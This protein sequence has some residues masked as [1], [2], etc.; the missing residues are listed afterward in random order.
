[1]RFL[2]QHHANPNAQSRG[3]QPLICVRCVKKFISNPKADYLE[4]TI[5]KILFVKWPSRCF[6]FPLQNLNQIFEK[7]YVLLLC[8]YWLITTYI[9]YVQ[10]QAIVYNINII[11]HNNIEGGGAPYVQHIAANYP[12]KR[13]HF[14]RRAIYFAISLHRSTTE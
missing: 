5:F 3:I 1:M 7:M 10:Y 2:L 13:G 14:G 8:V 9:I 4:M 11:C 12:P 6:F